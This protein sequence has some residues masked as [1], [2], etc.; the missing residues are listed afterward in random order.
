MS[1]VSASE[2]VLAFVSVSHDLALPSQARTSLSPSVIRTDNDTEWGGGRAAQ[3]IL[4]F[5][6]RIFLF[7]VKI[8]VQDF[9]DLSATEIGL[10]REREGEGLDN[11]IFDSFVTPFF[12]KDFQHGST[13]SVKVS[14]SLVI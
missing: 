2:S 5:T 7:S 8:C 9:P 6:D 12:S 14:Q 3:I 13:C 11:F 4:S 1:S 10:N